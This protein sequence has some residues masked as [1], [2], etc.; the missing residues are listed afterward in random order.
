MP[1]QMFIFLVNQA[2]HERHSGKNSHAGHNRSAG[3]G[4]DAEIKIK[5]LQLKQFGWLLLIYLTKY[6]VKILFRSQA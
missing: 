1:S 5:D 2:G 4:S 3:H 6:V